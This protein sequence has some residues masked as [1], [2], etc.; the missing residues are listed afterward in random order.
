MPTLQI[1]NVELYY[2][3]IGQGE[4]V[5]FIHGLGSSTRDWQP[6][7]STF[8]K[9][10]QVILFD[11]RGHGQSEKPPG[12]YSIPLFAKDTALLIE[13]LKL[14]PLPVIGISMGGMIAFQ[15]AVDRPD[16]V[17]KLVVVNAGPEFAI[18]TFKER[19]KIWQRFLVV[20]LSGMRK[21]GE[22]L[23]K[24]M[25]I[26][27]DQGNLRKIF[28]DRWA[29][30]DTQPYCDSMKAIVGWSVLDK[31]SEIHCPTL[32]LASDEDYTP[33]AEKQAYV[34]MLPQGELVVIDDARHALPVER[35]AEFNAALKSF[36]N[37]H[38]NS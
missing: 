11:V 20:R 32:V 30:N 31:I 19:L 18:H 7:V 1:N 22:I 26:K 4:P 6:Q 15:L 33:V 21:I 25:F 24:R 36:L 5:L 27:E 37:K 14:P 28:V 17:N 2:K 16:L 38:K 34:K 9:H 23:S 10:Y 3:I 35:P 29:E 12:P 13:Q 8:A